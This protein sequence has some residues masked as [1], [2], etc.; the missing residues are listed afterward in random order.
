MSFFK[1]KNTTLRCGAIIDIG[2]GS[3][4]VAIV[5]SDTVT[6]TFE[7]IWSHREYILIKKM[8]DEVQLLKEINTTLVTAFLELGSTGLRALHDY[9]ASLSIEEI[10]TTLSAPWARTITQTISYND[11]KSF[12]INIQLLE[13]LAQKARAQSLESAIDGKTLS[14]FGLRII[15]DTTIDVEING[16]SIKRPMGKKT[17]GVVLSHVHSLAPEAI[18]A[19]LEDSR[20]KILPNASL[21]HF[22]FMYLFYE[23]L[24]QLHPNTNDVCL[25][26]ITDEATEIAIVSGTILTSSSLI[27]IGLYSL[28]REIGASCKIPKEEAYAILKDASILPNYTKDQQSTIEVIIASFEES[29]VALFLRSGGAISIPNALFIHTSQNTEAFFAERLKNAAKNAT[30]TEHT[31][32]LVTSEVL[33]NKEVSDTALALSAHYFHTKLQSNLFSNEV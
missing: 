15:T 10:Q 4:G 20:E 31:I 8:A 27:N 9:N 17:T 6:K 25:I 22:S 1:E 23:V 30:V 18:L 21:A 2:S 24:K 32:H 11:E 12:I 28:A 19:V 16:Y 29:L 14:E 13:Q 3:V 7:I 26:D 33:Q 5:V